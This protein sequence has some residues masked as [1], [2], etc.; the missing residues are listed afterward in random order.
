[1]K[2]LAEYMVKSLVD[3]PEEVKITE[4]ESEKTSILEISVASDD[5]GKVVG[6]EGRIIKSLRI[7]LASS[8]AKKGKRVV[9][10]ML[11]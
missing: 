11:D 8:A 10:E 6:K 4:V 2:E 1:M 3:H 9:V 7:I 5:I